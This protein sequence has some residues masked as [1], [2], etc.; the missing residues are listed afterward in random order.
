[1]KK[2]LPAFLP[3]LALLTLGGCATTSNLATTENDGMYYSALDRVTAPAVAPMA[4]MPSANPG[5][6][7]NPDYNGSGTATR[8]G[9]EYYDDDYYYASRLR[10]FN[11]PYRGSSLGY[12][13][14]AYTDPFFYGSPVFAYSPYSPYGY[15]DPFARPYYGYGGLSINI[16]FGYGFGRPYYRPVGYGYSYD[17]YG[18]GY[19]PGSPWGGYYGGYGGGRYARNYYNG[20]GYYGGGSGYYG[21]GYG[22]NWNGNNDQPGRQRTGRRD[23]VG[24]T[25]NASDTPVGGRGRV[26]EGGFTTAPNPNQQ[27][28]LVERPSRGR[29]VQEVPTSGS[30]AAGTSGRM[31]AGQGAATLG[32][33][34]QLGGRRG[35][36][37]EMP[38]TNTTPPV[39]GGR[40]DQI[41]ADQSGR[42]MSGTEQQGGRR[43]RVLSNDG[44]SQPVP[45]TDRS[46]DNPYQRRSRSDWNPAGSGSA[47]SPEQPR[48]QRISEN[49]PSRPSYSQPS[50]SSESSRPARA[51]E[52]SRSYSQPSQSS[53][54]SQPSRSYSEPSRSSNSNSGNS[55]S[56]AAGGRRGR[57]E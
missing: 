18:Y 53:Q 56:G 42:D 20:G 48:R 11:T 9:A 44:G 40:R 55:G 15:Y 16:G 45:T 52:P 50:R 32:N 17:P 49:A 12:Y 43:W 54:S 19:Y 51:S 7:A 34:Q 2:H 24:D 22:S 38:N 4:D 28:G 5:D 39:V 29:R 13:D 23:W 14:F 1:M 6:I 21:N 35:R 57:V 33:D 8:G 46:G 47:S 26:Q 36:I 27:S 25:R 41:S 10:R 37:Q 31:Q 30:G 3:A